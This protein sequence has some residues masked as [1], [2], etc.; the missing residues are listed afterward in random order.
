M[1][2]G[3]GHPLALPVGVQRPRSGGLTHVRAGPRLAL[4]PVA[5]VHRQG[6]LMG[7][8]EHPSPASSDI[9]PAM[10]VGMALDV[11]GRQVHDS[12]LIGGSP[13]MAEWRR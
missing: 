7:L 11:L 1:F 10:V 8:L 12:R 2:A 5:T 9:G 13:P 3:T 4:D 6:E